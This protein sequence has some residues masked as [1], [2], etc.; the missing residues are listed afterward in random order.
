M[1]KLAT[2]HRRWSKDPEYQAAYAAAAPEFAMA[3]KLI[4][5][6]LKS[7]LSQLELAVRMGTTQSAIAR[8][9]SGHSL[10]SMRSLVR[11][12][13]ATQCELEIHLKPATAH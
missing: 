8:M 9:E 4:E 3:R 1:T 5:A 13:E 10:P 6:R 7:G 11:Y 12:A 2:L